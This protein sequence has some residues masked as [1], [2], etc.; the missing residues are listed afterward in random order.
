MANS[1]D[2]IL[3]LDLGTT[4]IKVGLFATSGELRRLASREQQLLFPQSDWVEQSLADTWQLVCDAAREV[5]ADF[6]SRQV[7]SVVVTV[8]RG[9]VVPLDANCEPLTNMIVWMDQRGLG[10]VE[11]LLSAVGNE[12]YYQTSGHPIVPITGVSKVLWL[13]QEAADIWKETAFVGSP[14]TVFLH[15]LGCTEPLVDTSTGSYLFPND[16]QNKTWSRTI[17]DTLTFPLKRLP[18]LVEATELVGELSERAAKDLG[19]RSGIPIV[20]GGGDGQCAAA[21]T[22]V[23]VPGS[24]MVNIGTA[25]GVQVFLTEPSFDPAQTLNCAA[26]VVQGAWE[27]EGHTQA[28]GT[29]FRWFRDEFGAAELAEAERSNLDAYDLLVEQAGEAPPGCDDL[30]FL[31]TFN[32]STAPIVDPHA[33]GAFI[34]LKLAHERRHIIRSILEGI[35]L[36]IRWML[37]TIAAAGVPVEEIRLAGGGSKNA[38]WNQ[39]HADILNRPIRTVK[40]PDAALVGAAMCAAVALGHYADF[41]AAAEAFVQLTPMIEPRNENAE[42]YQKTYDRY[43]RTFNFLSNNQIFVS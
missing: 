10:Q 3:S 2:T 25:A 21:G 31:P 43:V 27:M 39:I 28:S 6:D 15:W 33:R 4:A 32:G 11:R 18:R 14:Q 42:V 24:V 19:L 22:G 8:Q 1:G 37:D 34:G 5:L 16:I 30:I 40:N 20:A 35:S 17:A 7:Q 41:E 23:V 29:V 13:H 9:S 36:E 26:H 12:T 38:T